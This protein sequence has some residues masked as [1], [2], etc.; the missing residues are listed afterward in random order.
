M[1]H[2]ILASAV[3]LAFGTANA[4]DIPTWMDPTG[5]AEEINTS[6]LYQ[7]T[8]KGGYFAVAENGGSNSA[9]ITIL[10]EDSPF[11]L[12]SD[13]WL[14]NKTGNNVYG[15]LISG[16]GKVE[17]TKNIYVQGNKDTFWKTKAILLGNGSSFTNDGLIYAKNA[18]GVMVLPGS[19]VNYTN[20]NTIVVEGLGV[21]M[22]MAGNDKTSTSV[23]GEMTNRGDIF[24]IEYS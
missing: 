9:G 4:A 6:E 16:S 13:T 22:D 11:T 17:N 10:T 12:K 15:A 20:N 23:S 19:R 2:T 1:K 21:A 18:Y 5:V 8:W 7:D 3:L 24:L 14:V